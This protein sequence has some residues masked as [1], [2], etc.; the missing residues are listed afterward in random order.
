M[1]PTQLF[2]LVIAMFLAIIALHYAA[3]RLGLPPSVAL[4]AGGAL[5]AFVP[6]LPAIT[7]DP[8]LVLVIFLPPLLMDGAWS[9]ALARLRRHMIGIASLAVGA[10]LFTCAIV[11]MT[12]HLFFPS[13][14][15]AACAALG[16][17]VSPPDAVSA[18]AVLERVRLP[19][20]LQILLEGESLLN[21]ASGLVLFR[22]AVAAAATGTFSAVEAVG[23]FFELALGGAVV[24]LVVGATWVKLVRRL[25]DEYLIIAATVLL[26]WISYLLGELLHVSGVIATVTTGLIASW[27]QHTV[28]SAAMRMRG[29]SFWTVMIFLME[30]AVFTLIGLSLRDVVERGG[31]F[32]TVIATM[33][34]PMLAILV[35][36]VIARFAWVFGSDLVIGFCAAFGLKRVQP[37]GAGGAVVLGWAGVR[38]VVTLAL[39]LSLPETFPGRDFILV[40]S[41]AVILG[42]VL[43]QGTTLGR[44]IAW[45]RLAEPPSERARLTM[46]QAEAAMAQAQ[47]GIV[48]NLAYD[49]EGKLIHP[50]LLE[51][52]QRR[53]TAIV[54][55][56]AR[57]EHYMPALHAHFDVVLEAVAAGRRELIRLHRAGE[58]D[59]ETLHELERDLDLEE[60]SAISAKA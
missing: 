24:G 7:V 57:T 15:W 9:I 11:A 4:L 60:L 59:D 36:L 38:G 21:D 41:F 13:L 23:D 27:H 32:A 50:Q 31:G 54:D 8:G 52:Y 29:T 26:A 3:R 18:R 55:Y 37:I 49:A 44:V 56:A 12:T 5:L 42:T 19:R 34:L 16:A 40:T 33:G 25:G 46:S 30:A 39:A 28:L 43:V 35:T 1:E 14:P 47:L 45:A 22:F 2:E 48:Q 20:R 58:I 10:V 17:I 53:A 6:G 51:R